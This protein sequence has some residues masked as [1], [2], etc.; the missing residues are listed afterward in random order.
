MTTP[1][2][3]LPDG[4]A[5]PYRLAL[6]GGG[7][8]ATYV[9]ERLSATVGRLGAHARLEVRVFER[10]GEFGAGQAHSPAQARTSYLNRIACQVSFAADESTPGAGPL[11]PAPE[12]PT[13]YEWCRRTFQ[14]TGD[15]DFDLRPEDW[16][17]RHVHGRAL[18]EM[19]RAYTAD[20]LRHPGTELHLHQAEVVDLAPLGRGFEVVTADGDRYRADE[21]LLLTGHSF[22]DPGRAASAPGGR[23]RHVPHPY[24]LEARLGP[25]QCG[26][27]D[28]VGCMGM[29]LTAIDTVL[30]LTE[31]R[32]GTFQPDSGG[33][34][35][36][37]PSGRE[38]E[39]VVAFSRSGLF[40]FARPDNHK[41]NGGDHP[42]TFLT[43]GAVDLLR[44]HRGTPASPE[45]G[46]G[47]AQLDF[48]RDVLPLAVLE[49]AHLHYV[50]LFGPGTALLLTQRVLPHWLAFLTGGPAAPR[51]GDLLAPLERA[52]DEIAEVLDAVL[53]GKQAVFT[54]ERTVGWPV[55]DVLLHWV[56]TVYGASAAY[57]VRRCVDRSVAPS[58][59]TDGLESPCGMDP[60]VH[61]NRFDWQRTVSPLPSCGSAAEVRAAV[62][63][64]MARDQLWARQ[65][66]A[67]NPHKA[68]ADGVWRDLRGVISYAVDDAGLT[69]A[70]QRH[71][72]STWVGHHNRLANGAAPEIMAKIIA[73]I[74]HGLLDV[75]A[76]RDARV[77]VDEATGR[78]F[79]E[80]PHTGLRRPVDVLVE[81]RMHGFDPRLDALP[82]YRS[83]LDR[84]L[85]RL[86]RNESPGGEVFEPGGLDLTAEFH[87]VGADGSADTRITVL[88]VPSEGARSFLLS[89][90]RPHVDHYVMRDVLVWL[91]GFWRAAGGRRLPA[92][93][94]DDGVSNR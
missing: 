37:L 77:R 5:E 59:E 47:R 51:T 83:L 42:G 65:G 31:G 3:A 55:R 74:E 20:L 10:T 22:H 48:E 93:V 70:S 12:R 53:R 89:A 1:R 54:A 87:P 50:T 73:L 78:A 75:G 90:L 18:S 88:G 79:V 61:G 56:R 8:R 64:F 24:P 15:P 9:M 39:A 19:F 33:G 94:A 23:T 34:L 85:V 58:A 69:P 82:L 91:D 43:T 11:R 86:W 30:H 81:A 25:E 28:V 6:V 49:M 38:P 62:L 27:S 40:T 46:A 16:P 76:G 67:G 72:L 84:G 13:L 14:E 36:Y 4:A 29:G 68:A 32:G 26:P 63:D 2:T 60:S 80:G 45:A 44:A 41:P 17:K 71:F 66:N 57:E 52:A 92:A 35:V 21:V 7:P